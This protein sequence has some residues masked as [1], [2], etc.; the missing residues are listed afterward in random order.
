MV[1]WV[2]R[3]GKTFGVSDFGTGKIKNVTVGFA[4]TISGEGSST[5]MDGSAARPSLGRGMVQGRSC[6]GCG[7]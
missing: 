2:A 5:L 3:I 7:G 4:G 6:E 1:V